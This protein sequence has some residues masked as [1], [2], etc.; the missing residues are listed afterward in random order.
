M[1]FSESGE[2]VDFP[3]ASIFEV[4]DVHGQ[5]HFV[6][7]AGSASEGDAVDSFLAGDDVEFMVG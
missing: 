2:V 3:N 4:Y 6:S 5:V 7:V 1:Q